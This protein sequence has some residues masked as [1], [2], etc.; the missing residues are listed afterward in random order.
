MFYVGKGTGKRRFELHNRNQYFNNV[1]NKYDCAVRIY[2]IGLTNEEAFEV[3]QDRIAELKLRGMAKCNINSGGAGFAEG[4]LNPIHERI[5]DEDYINP[6]SVLIFKGEDNHF[7]GKKHT[8]ETKRKISRSRMGKG[9]RF[10]K[11]NPMYGKGLKGKDNPMYG[12]TGR[13]H[14]NARMYEIKYTDGTV[15]ELTYKEC[16]KK[17][18]IAFTRVSKTGGKLHYK[19]KSKNSIYEDTI[20]NEIKC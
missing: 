10:G 8:E 13:Q 15:E 4:S 9:G 7:Y 14:P 5:K 20:I 12:R 6:F 19:N 3:E 16:E 1:Y 11:D 17:F 2:R 18:G